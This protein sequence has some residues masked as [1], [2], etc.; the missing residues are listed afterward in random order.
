MNRAPHG[1]RPRTLVC[2]LAALS[3]GACAADGGEPPAGRGSPPAGWDDGL[4]QPERRIATPPPTSSRSTS[5]RA[6]RPSSWC[7]GRL[8]R[9]DV[10]RGAARGRSFACRPAAR[11]LVHFH[12]NLPEETTVHWHGVRL[13]ADMDGVPEHSQPVVLPGGSFDYSFTVP[14]SR[15]VLVPPARP[16][17]QAGRR[18]SLRRAAGRAAPRQRG[19]ASDEPRRAGRR[20]GDGVVGHRHRRPTAACPIPIAAASWARCSDAKA[21]SCSSTG[22]SRRRS[23]ARLGRRQRWRI[24]NTAK[25]RYFQIALAGHRFVR[26]GGD[27]G[28]LPAPQEMDMLVLTPGE[29]ADVLVTPQGEPGARLPVRWVPF[30]RG[31]GSA[32]YRPEVEM[33]FLQLAD[34]PPI[35]EDPRCRRRCG[36]SSRST[37]ATPCP[38]RINLTQAT[39]DNKFVLGINGVPSWQAEPMHARVGDTELWTVSNEMEWDHPFHLHGFFFQ[40][41]DLRRGC[42]RPRPSGRTRQ[43]PA[44]E[45]RPRSPCATTIAPA[46]GCSTATS[47]TTPTRA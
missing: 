3:A 7:R 38:G 20:A 44:P 26:I 23:L 13:T 29:R 33:F 30:N 9:V 12:N 17:G 43:R 22:G 24:V 16:L 40:V 2:F 37:S 42:R 25:T 45:D 10:R 1:R 5:R 28:L 19:T 32:E 46:C 6:S 4:R 36:T 21:T 34:D 47:W 27:G 15:A 35:V 41:V 14:D 39:I 8:P 18:R 11:L 31:F